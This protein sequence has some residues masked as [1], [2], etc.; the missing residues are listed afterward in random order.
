MSKTVAEL[1]EWLQSPGINKVILLE[2]KGVDEDDTG[3]F[4]LYFSNK[5]YITEDGTMYDPCIVGGISFT[6]SISLTENPA[7]NYGEIELDNSDTAAVNRLTYLRYGWKNRI[8]N[9]YIGD[10]T[11]P[12]YDFS[13]IFSGRTKDLASRGRNSLSLSLADRLSLINVPVYRGQIGY[14]GSAP[15][16]ITSSLIPGYTGST[17]IVA[18]LG[19]LKPVTIGECFNVSPVLIAESYYDGSELYGKLFMYHDGNAGGVIEVRDNGAPVD[20]YI[21][22]FP[23]MFALTKSS[24]GTI[25]ASVYGN[26]TTAGHTYY[27]GSKA[28]GYIS[29]TTGEPTY[30]W[31]QAYVGSAYL[32]SSYSTYEDSIPSVIKTLLTAY[33]G[34]SGINPNEIDFPYTDTRCTGVFVSDDSNILSLCTEVA[35]SGG[36][37]LACNVIDVTDENAEP[38]V[39]KIKLIEINL[40]SP[41]TALIDIE[42]SD[43]IQHSLVMIDKI[44]AK[45]GVQLGY[46]KNWTVQE[47]SSLAEGLVP[48]STRY[49]TEEYF[50][51]PWTSI[52]SGTSWYW[53]NYDIGTPSKE[54]SLLLNLTAAEA[55][56]DRREELHDSVLAVYKITLLP[57][58]M[59]IQA[60]DYIFLDLNSST[61]YDSILTG[62]GLVLSVQRNWLDS[63]ITLTVLTKL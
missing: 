45:P 23:G 59:F 25:T 21:D 55:E 7:L 46:A 14:A 58:K 5:P 61:K 10:A 62:N 54:T 29:S 27:T 43:T 18:E 42:E 6:E 35:N 57:H 60:G 38:R 11:W 36:Y 31:N 12:R 15:Q 13:L 52:P 41:P 19:S 50:Y 39:G 26:S 8:A 48:Q 56:K 53:G 47:Y 51:T 49:F 37:A 24:Y 3:S 16:Y 2:I 20:G 9:I 34:S 33:A 63:T 30:A 44:A 28:I 17:P 4:N 1:K 32:G 40:L 22:V